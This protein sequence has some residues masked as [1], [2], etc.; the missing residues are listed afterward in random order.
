[1]NAYTTPLTLCGFNSAN[2]D[3]YLFINILM[4]SEYSKRPIKSLIIVQLQPKILMMY[5]TP[6]NIIKTKTKI[7]AIKPNNCIYENSL[8]E[9]EETKITHDIFKDMYLN[10]INPNGVTEEDMIFYSS[11]IKNL[12]CLIA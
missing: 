12:L 2:Y 8:T 3:F 6:E 7:N 5:I 11:N 9:K 4:K 1:M 10:T